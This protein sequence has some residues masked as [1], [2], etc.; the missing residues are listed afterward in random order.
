MILL[1]L[2]LPGC[3]KNLRRPESAPT[4]PRVVCT[5]STPELI[6]PIPALSGMDE[7]AIKVM[8]IYQREVIKRQNIE[9]CLTQLRNQGI[10]R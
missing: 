2:G 7:W 1:A 8:G 3:A 9:S 6:P 4:P 10:I 5:A